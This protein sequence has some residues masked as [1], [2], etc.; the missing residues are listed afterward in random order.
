MRSISDCNAAAISRVAESVMT[1][2]RSSGFNRRQTSIAFRAPGTNSGSIGWEW[3]R[4][5]ILKALRITPKS[6]GGKRSGFVAGYPEIRSDDQWLWRRME[7]DDHLRS[8]HQRGS[9]LQSGFPLQ[10]CSSTKRRIRSAGGVLSNS[11]CGAE[12]T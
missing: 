9:A 10:N 12:Q 1:V 6:S 2:I 8:L 11:L 3:A 7:E 5:G 4:S